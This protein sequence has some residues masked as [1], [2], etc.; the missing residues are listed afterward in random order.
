MRQLA[1]LAQR[2]ERLLPLQGQGGGAQEAARKTLDL[3]VLTRGVE[4]GLADAHKGLYFV[5][6]DEGTIVGQVMITYEWSDWRNGW[7]WWLQS[8]Y[9]RAQYRGRGVFRALYEHVY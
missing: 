2:H 4:A 7:I 1:G 3:S 9:V 8:V 5:A 6:E